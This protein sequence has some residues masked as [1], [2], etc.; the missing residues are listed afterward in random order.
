MERDQLVVVDGGQDEGQDKEPD[1]ADAG[2]GQPKAG[3]DDYGAEENEAESET[4]KQAALAG[5]DQGPGGVHA[6][7]QK[8]DGMNSREQQEKQ[9][10]TL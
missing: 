6:E 8:R 10:R 4:D 7:D 1:A 3:G 5:G 2:R 9:N